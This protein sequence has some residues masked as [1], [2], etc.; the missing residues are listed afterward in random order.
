MNLEN[1]IVLSLNDPSVEHLHHIVHILVQQKVEGSIG[2]CN[3]ERED[4]NYDIVW[5]KQDFCTYI[6][7]CKVHSSSYKTILMEERGLTKACSF[8]HHDFFLNSCVK[9]IPGHQKVL[10]EFW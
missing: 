5:T 4:S 6:H 2:I 7:A 9:A 8:N 10:G 3:D 1:I